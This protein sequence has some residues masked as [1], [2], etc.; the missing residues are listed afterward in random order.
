MALRKAV[1]PDP[2]LWLPLLAE[3]RLT[4]LPKETL[5]EGTLRED[6][7]GASPEVRAAL[8]AWP[9]SAHLTLERDGT[10]VVLVYR[11]FTDF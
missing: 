4:S 2:A 11:L 10:H 6:L 8:E 7:T 5:L 9:A 1:K 3:Y